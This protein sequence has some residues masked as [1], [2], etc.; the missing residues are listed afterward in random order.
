MYDNVL[1]ENSYIYDNV[2]NLVVIYNR[3]HTRNIL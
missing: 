1:H 3:S 2:S